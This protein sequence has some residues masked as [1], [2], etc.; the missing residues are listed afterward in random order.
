MIVG[1]KTFQFCNI[2][3]T[4]NMQLRDLFRENRTPNKYF[5]LEFIIQTSVLFTFASFRS[6][7]L[8]LINDQRHFSP[9]SRHFPG[10]SRNC[11]LLFFGTVARFLYFTLKVF[12]FLR[13]ATLQIW[14]FCLKALFDAS[15]WYVAVSFTF[16]NCQIF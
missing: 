16:F 7:I 13:I 3:L 1:Y 9:E 12:N 6:K 2:C 4:I 15:R 8:R 11:L 5:W 14:N 10:T